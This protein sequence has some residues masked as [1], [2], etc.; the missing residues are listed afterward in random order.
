ME[1]TLSK[2]PPR[3]APAGGSGASATARG[4][5]LLR[6]VKFAAAVAM[7][8]ICVGMTHGTYEIVH[9]AWNSGSAANGASRDLAMWF[10]CGAAAFAVVALLLWRPVVLYVFAHELVHALATWLCL[11]SVSNFR[12]SASGGSVVSSKSNTLIRLAPYCLPLYALLAAGI[13]LALDHWWRP[14]NAQLHWAMFVLGFFYAFHIGFSVWSMRRDQPDLKPDGWFFS[15]VAIYLAN[16][17]VFA[18]MIGFVLTGKA[19]YAWPALR[20]ASVLGWHHSV[21]TYQHIADSLRDVY[22]RVA[23]R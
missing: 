18:L 5:A 11:G 16:L 8:P 17:A 4:G 10:G 2:A 14:L 23:N 15:L 6:F 9:A 21:A 3:P 19:Q 1:G 13:Y 12:A 7:L 20:S 22:T